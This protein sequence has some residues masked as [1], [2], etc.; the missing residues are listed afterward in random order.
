MSYD[1]VRKTPDAGANL[2][3][4]MDA[5]WG[6]PNTLPAAATSDA[7]PL[8][9]IHR[10]LRGRYPLALTL[11]LIGALIGAGIG[12]STQKPSYRATGSVTISPVLQSVFDSS[13]N[14]MPLYAQYMKSQAN[15]FRLDI[16][17]AAVAQDAWKQYNGEPT[18]AAEIAYAY[19]ISASYD[20]DSRD[21]SVTFQSN[22]SQEAIL[23]VNSALDA[24]AALRREE[25]AK[26]SELSL[27]AINRVKGEIENN[28]DDTRNK[29]RQLGKQHESLDLDAIASGKQSRL[30]ELEKQLDKATDVLTRMLDQKNRAEANAIQIDPKQL[31]GKDPLLAQMLTYKEQLMFQQTQLGHGANSPVAKNLDAKIEAI[32]TQIDN[33]AKTL[34][35]DSLGFIPSFDEKGGM[36]EVSLLN[37]AQQEATVEAKKL[38]IEAIRKDLSGVETSRFEIDELEGQIKK[39]DRQLEDVVNR[40]RLWEARG[41][42]SAAPFNINKAVIADLADDRRPTMATF[43]FLVGGGLPVLGVLLLGLADRRYRYSDEATGGGVTKGIPL[44]GI[45]PNLPDRLSDP[46]QASVAAHCVHQ[47]RTMLQLNVLSDQPSIL[48]I[49]SAASGDGK[50][51]LTLALGLSFAAAGSRTL[52]IDTDLIGAGLSARLGV[53]APQGVGDAIISDDPSQF[54][55]NTDVTDL[56]IIPVGTQTS[57]QNSAFSPTAVR[58]LFSELRGKYDIILVDTGPVLGSIEATPLVAAADATIL[59]VARGQNRDLVEKAIAHLKSVGAKIAGVVFNRAGSKDFERSIS[60]ISLRSVSRASQTHAVNGH[61][62]NGSYNGS[63]SSTTGAAN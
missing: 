45:L 21:I 20:R 6:Q 35:K 42:T 54:V 27:D 41:I 1:I 56:S 51:S 46:S 22:D 8:K 61:N 57:V 13:N 48:A 52:L 3:S 47:I 9:V 39:L 10:S 49:T 12:Y 18:Q 34:A 37:I 33:L 59:T 60:G 7:Q 26:E 24:Y 32:A 38:Q 43:G 40:Q 50:T 16:P 62:G 28:I 55:R 53:N 31:A 11:G 44:L 29:I 30:I 23:G 19:R 14:S 2:P 63:T 25:Q 5:M 4:T 58:R 17:R 15:R 36:I